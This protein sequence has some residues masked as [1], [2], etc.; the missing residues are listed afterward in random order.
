MADTSG[1]D[2]LIIETVP[3]LLDAVVDSLPLVGLAFATGLG[4]GASIRD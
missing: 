1:M 2:A 3:A 4:V